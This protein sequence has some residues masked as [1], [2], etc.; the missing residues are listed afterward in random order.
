[1]LGHMIYANGEDANPDILK[2]L[3]YEQM[4]LYAPIKLKEGI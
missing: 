3:G 4:V 1:M 2:G